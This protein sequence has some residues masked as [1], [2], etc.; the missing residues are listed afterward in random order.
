[1]ISLPF[2]KELSPNVIAALIGAGAT[3]IAA[4]INLRVAWRREVL[5][6]LNRPRSPRKRRGLLLAI[7]ILVAAAGI[8]GYATAL[9]LMQH[10]QQSTRALR[11][12]LQQRIAEI[13][14]TAVRL[15][16][17]RLGEQTAQ[18]AKV[19]RREERRR[20]E[21]GVMAAARI[22]P[23]AVRGSATG[24]DPARPTAA[25]CSEADAVAVAVCAAV[26]AAATV[27]ELAPYVRFEGDAAA[28]SEQ[29]AQLGALVGGKAGSVRLGALAS[30]RPDGDTGKQVCLDVR[31]WE[32]E[33]ALEVRV[34]VKYLLGDAAPP[35]AAAP[36]Q[37]VGFAH[38]L[39]RQDYEQGGSAGP[40][41]DPP[42]TKK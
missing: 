3:L 22:A 6:R 10:E 14:E 4:F 19:R 35:A 36:V 13:Q 24:D 38:R 28:W 16:Q 5:D 29:R 37:A 11:T 39:G 7:F 27:Y 12:D 20:G 26:P 23:C 15:E 34:V 30:E 8:G 9:Y 42:A 21:E 41:V 1:M 40:L 33:R 32:S 18:E 31:S 2:I 25:A 17:A